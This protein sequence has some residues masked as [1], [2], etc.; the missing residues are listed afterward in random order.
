[1]TGAAELRMKV[2]LE[3]DRRPR[4]IYA[5]KNMLWKVIN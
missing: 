4:N 2:L 1:M 5:L 3:P